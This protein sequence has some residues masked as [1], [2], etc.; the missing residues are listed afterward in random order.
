MKI[1]VFKCEQTGKL[2]EDEKKYQAHL[3]KL[4]AQNREKRKIAVAESEADAWWNSAYQREMTIEEWP[5]FV[6]DNQKYFWNDASKS[7]FDWKNTVG[8]TRGGVVCPTPELLEFTTFN[9][10]WS[11]RVSNSHSAPHNG[12]TNWGPGNDEIPRSYPGWCGRVEWIVRWPREWDGH[13][14]GGSLFSGDKTRR[15]AYSGTGGGGGMRYN[16]KHD[17]YV[18][19][20]GYDFRMFAA[21]WP[22]MARVIAKQQVWDVMCGNRETTDGCLLDFVE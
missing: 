3:R 14:I 4:A 21:D 2:F 20:F 18:Q 9:V 6:I 11:P 17:C 12:V 8:R 16:D 7:E 19:S 13:Y 15:R 1:T 5:Q 10:R 22:G